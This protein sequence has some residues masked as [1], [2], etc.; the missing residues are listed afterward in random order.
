MA[1]SSSYT[2]LAF[3]GGARNCIG[4][5]LSYF[6]A[7]IIFSLFIKKFKYVLSDPNY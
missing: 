2:F 6:E 5:H 4:Q 3:S 7:K 1:A